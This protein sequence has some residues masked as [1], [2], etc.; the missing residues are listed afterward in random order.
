MLLTKYVKNAQKSLKTTNYN[1][2]WTKVTQQL[3]V[4]QHYVRNDVFTP[5]KGFLH[6]IIIGDEK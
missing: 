3:M 6:R 5:Q 4:E 1:P 2:Y